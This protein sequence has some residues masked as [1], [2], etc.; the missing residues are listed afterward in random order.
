MSRKIVLLDERRAPGLVRPDG[1]AAIPGAATEDGPQPLMETNVRDT[2]AIRRFLDASI[3]DMT[4]QLL[5]A[6]RECEAGRITVKQF[7]ET[8]AVAELISTWL[9]GSLAT[10]DTMMK[11][12]Q[13]QPDNVA[14]NDERND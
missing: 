1:G 6:K 7:R 14:D 10:V 8:K 12:A 9:I 11:A 13:L 2:L 5:H 4:G 3:R